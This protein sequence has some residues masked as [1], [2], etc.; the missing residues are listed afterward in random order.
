MRVLINTSR[1]TLFVCEAESAGFDERFG[2]FL[3]RCGSTELMNN[4]L[5]RPQAEDLCRSALITGTLDLTP[6]GR[7]YFA[8]EYNSEKRLIGT[9]DKSLW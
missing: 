3:I 2:V 8:D 5:S 9:E 1:S 6:Y 7:T 4:F